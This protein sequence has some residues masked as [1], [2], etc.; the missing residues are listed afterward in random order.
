MHY[1]PEKETAIAVRVLETGELECISAFGLNSLF[2]LQ[3]SHNPQ[4]DK[5][6]FN[7]RVKSKAWLKQW[8]LLTIK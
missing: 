6:V 5:A 3:L 1:W 4:R 2:N 7:Q 8:P